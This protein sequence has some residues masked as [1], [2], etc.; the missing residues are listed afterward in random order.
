MF[1]DPIDNPQKLPVYKLK[2]LSV[3]I[4]SGA[5]PRGGKE[6]Y[7]FDG[8]PFIRSLN[9]HNGVFKYEDLAH[10]STLQADQLSNVTVYL[11]DLLFNITGAS[12]TRCCVVPD[13]ITSA[14]VNQHVCIIRTKK[15]L[16]DS[17]Y[18]NKLFLTDSYHD[19]L[20]KLA[21]SGG[22]TR[23]AITKQQME[24]LLIM[25]PTIEDQSK[26]S[27]FCH[28]TEKSKFASI[29]KLQNRA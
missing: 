6:S 13:N 4:G 24:E 7:P 8:I 9:V 14:R 20:V 28:L 18:L 27:N 11:E 25:L 3:K 16:L 21:E 17:L 2:D 1:G 29:F 19:Y 15:N 12:V 5:T 10:P 23:Q 26:F 22:A